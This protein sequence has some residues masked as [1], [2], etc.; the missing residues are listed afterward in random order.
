MSIIKKNQF[1][2]TRI[3]PLYVSHEK[4]DDRDEDGNSWQLEDMEENEEENERGKGLAGAHLIKRSSS[5]NKERN[6]YVEAI[7]TLTQRIDKAG[8]ALLKSLPEI[9]AEAVRRAIGQIDASDAVTG[10]VNAVIAENNLMTPLRILASP[11]DADLLNI[12]QQGGGFAQCEIVIDPLLSDGEAIIECFLGRIHAG[13]SARG[14]EIGRAL[15]IGH[16]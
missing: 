9:T 3:S 2:Q 13:P 6:H 5:I 7:D 10:A 1:D 11:R 8:Q 15:A 4:N 16:M 12:H 14:A